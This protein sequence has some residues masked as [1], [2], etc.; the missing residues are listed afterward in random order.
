MEYIIAGMIYTLLGY[1]IKVYQ[2]MIAMKISVLTLIWQSKRMMTLV[3]M[4]FELLNILSFSM[5]YRTYFST[6]CW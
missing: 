1:N 5:A 3:R 4:I 2:N 6:T